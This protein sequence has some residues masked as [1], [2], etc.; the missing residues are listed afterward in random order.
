MNKSRKIFS[1]ITFILLSITCFSQN[2]DDLG[3]YTAQIDSNKLIIHLVSDST[4]DAKLQ[5]GTSHGFYEII[6]DSENPIYDK[7]IFGDLI[8]DTRN[9]FYFF[10]VS[11]SKELAESLVDS[12][13]YSEDSFYVAMCDLTGDFVTYFDV[14]FEDSTGSI[15]MCDFNERNKKAHIIPSW[16]SSIGMIGEQS[17]LSSYFK[18]EYNRTQGSIAYVIGLSS[19]R[20]LINKDRSCILYHPCY[21]DSYNSDS[22]CCVVFIKSQGGITSQ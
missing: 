8:Y 15:L 5:W 18:S 22:N 11:I 12:N 19:G 17:N 9:A 21:C 7:I 16:A 20:F 3:W 14:C 4:Y 6:T 13:L 1:I 2:Q 10:H